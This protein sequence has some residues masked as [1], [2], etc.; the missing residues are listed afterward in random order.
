M[1]K[2]LFNR[3]AD[4]LTEAVK[5]EHLLTRITGLNGHLQ[6]VEVNP[7]NHQQIYRP[8]YTPFYSTYEPKTNSSGNGR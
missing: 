8:K 7:A 3:Y 6:T 1:L 5:N 4:I 2:P